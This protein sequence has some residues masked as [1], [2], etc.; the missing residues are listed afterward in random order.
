MP[1]DRPG[2]L[3]R[4]ANADILAFIL[5]TNGFP[6]GAKELSADSGDLKVIRFDAVR[7]PETPP[8]SKRKK[9]ARPQ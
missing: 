5:K 2:S 8:E 1:L 4:A 9:S 7:P 3:S 6:A